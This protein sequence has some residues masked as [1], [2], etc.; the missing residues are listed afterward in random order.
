[1]E[2]NKFECLIYNAIEIAR[3]CEN[4]ELLKVKEETNNVNKKS[5][6]VNNLGCLIKKWSY[7]HR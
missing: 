1:M 7:R 5:F 3:V 4:G 6:L 2:S